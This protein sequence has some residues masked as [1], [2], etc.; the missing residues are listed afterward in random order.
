[1]KRIRFVSGSIALVALIAAL[2]TM[3]VTGTVFTWI[4]GGLTLVSLVCALVWILLLLLRE[5]PTQKG[6][7]RTVQGLNT[8]LASIIFLGICVT[9]YAFTVRWDVSLDLT[10]EG[11]TEFAP[12][13]IQLLQ[14]LGEDVQVM[15]FF[16]GIGGRDVEIASGKVKRFM[17]RCQDLSS[18]LKVE[19]LDL[20]QNPLRLQELGIAGVPQE[21]AGLIILKCGQRKRAIML[22]GVNPTLKEGDFTNGLINVARASSS[23]IYFLTGHREAIPKGPNPQ[24]SLN[25]LIT[26]LAQEGYS[27]DVLTLDLLE[28]AVPDDCDVLVIAGPEDDIFRSET[29]ALQEYK[30]RGGRILVM[31]D[32]PFERIPTLGIDENLRPWLEWQWGVTIGNDMI[33][34]TRNVQL[35]GDILLSPDLTPFPEEKT[36]EEFYGSY[37]YGHTIS[38][39]LAHQMI[40]KHASTVTMA[41]KRPEGVARNILL[42]TQP[43]A[44]AE[45]NLALI[46]QKGQSAP[47]IHEARG[48]LPLA[49]AAT[50]QTDVT[51]GDT[52]SNR[53]AR[54]VVVGDSTFVTDHELPHN[55]GNKD[56][57]MNM[58]AWLTESEE[59]IAVRAIGDDQTPIILGQ[60]QKQFI[61]WVSTLGSLQLVLI[62]GLATCFFRRKFQ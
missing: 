13:T 54:I 40:F 10:K 25:S 58:L 12:Q 28:P 36:T 21:A 9:L 19:Y 53:D 33:I 32:P 11:R 42:R 2:N 39:G 56:V 8:V 57:V 60:G 15:C 51:V 4:V 59:L 35:P 61:A 24:K 6:R 41:A 46:N 55:A 50:A 30:D 44:W 26:N 18:R 22:E 43:D 27:A 37:N 38:R 48:P 49:V 7:F 34:S 62:A 3:L 23:K 14:S 1:M 20:Y 5:D 31:A 47:D 16:P 45:T 17:R 52:G 29:A